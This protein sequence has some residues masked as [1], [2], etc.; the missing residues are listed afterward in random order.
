MRALARRLSAQLPQSSYDGMSLVV[1]DRSLAQDAERFFAH[2]G[3]AL[4]YAAEHAPRSYAKLR[5][6]VRTIVLRPGTIVSVYNPF[7]LAVLVPANLLEAEAPAY[8]AWL[9]YMSGLSVGTREAFER[10]SEVLQTMD[11]ELREN[12]RLLFPHPN[13]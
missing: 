6:D 3:G 10:S 13:G 1:G 9:L 8:A 2:T 7:Q 12:A 5:K 11:P 4:R